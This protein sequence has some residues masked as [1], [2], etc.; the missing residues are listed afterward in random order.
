MSKGREGAQLFASTPCA[1][2]QRYEPL[3]CLIAGLFNGEQVDFGA[4]WNQLADAPPPPAHELSATGLLFAVAGA[5][6]CTRGVASRAPPGTLPGGDV[7]LRAGD[8]GPIPHSEADAKQCD[9]AEAAVA[10][11]A[12][13][14]TQTTVAAAR[15]CVLR[16]L[17]QLP[18]VAL[19]GFRAHDDGALADVSQGAE[20]TELDVL[21]RRA[22]LDVFPQFAACLRVEAGKIGSGLLGDDGERRAL[23]VVM[24]LRW[25][26]EKAHYTALRDRLGLG[27]PPLLRI[28]DKCSSLAVRLVAFGALHFILDRGMAAE[29]KQFGPPLDHCFSSGAPL[30]CGTGQALARACVAPYVAAYVVFLAKIGDGASTAFC[31]SSDSSGTWHGA[32]DTLLKFGFTHCSGEGLAFRL[33]LQCGLIPLIRLVPH[34]LAPRLRW[35]AGTLLQATESPDVFEVL[36]AWRAVHQLFAGAFRPRV[37]RYAADILLRAAFSHLTFV[38]SSP[39]PELQL[40]PRGMDGTDEEQPQGNTFLSPVTAAMTA[41]EWCAAEERRDAL[42][43]ILTDVVALLADV[44]DV[45]QMLCELDWH[46]SAEGSVPPRPPGLSDQLLRFVVFTRQVAASAR[47]SSEVTPPAEIQSKMQAS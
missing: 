27:L 30:F 28:L 20:A 17:R 2:E 39:P 13:W 25:A 11:L 38:A 8:N 32:G 34:L 42:R 4:S 37:K 43:G 45:Q 44:A 21:L 15:R 36:S 41:A 47:T 1:R 35:V 33:F 40:P 9:E 23:A 22:F 26:Y 14:V 19:T 6:L 10:A 5:F 24:S 46:L 29:I 18:D 7:R 31:G 3:S 12:P 16:W